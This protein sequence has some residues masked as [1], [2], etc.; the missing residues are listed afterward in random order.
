MPGSGSV[1]IHDE[2]VRGG[3]AQGDDQQPWEK[4]DTVTQKGEGRQPW[5]RGGRGVGAI[6]QK[7]C[8]HHMV[9]LSI[10]SEGYPLYPMILHG[11]SAH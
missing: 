10:Q 9:A 6:P 2:G 4:F 1:Y 7:E 3:G 11:G 5:P 8:E